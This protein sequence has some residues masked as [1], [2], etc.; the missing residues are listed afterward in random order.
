MPEGTMRMLS[1]PHSRLI[2]YRI[3]MV[4]A[5]TLFL[6]L[7]TAMAHADESPSARLA[8]LLEERQQWRLREFPEFAIS[9]GDYR[10]ADHLADMSLA[11]VER[12]NMQTQECLDR[13]H[14]IPKQGLSESD[15][16]SYEVF[17]LSLSNDVEGHGYRMFLAPI[18]PRSGPHQDIPQMHERVRF[19]SPDDYVNYIQRLR[20]VPKSV[21]DL[22]ET[23][24]A[25]VKEG[26]TPPRV[27]LEGLT[28]QFKA[29]TA[30]GGLDG[31]KQP[32][33]KFPASF[34]EDQ[35][36]EFA[37]RLT[38][39]A[40]PLVRAA[41]QKLGAYVEQE[42][43]PGCRETIAAADLPNG[44]AYY[45]FRVREETTTPEP[46]VQIHRIGMR[47]VSRIKREMMAVIRRSDFL[48][49]HPQT[50]QLGDE[51][52]FAAFV[53]YLRTDPRFYHTSEDE[54]LRGYRDI[55]KRIDAELPRLF[56]T[57]PRLPYGVRAIPKFMAPTQ[58]T[59]YYQ[60]GDI[61]NS[62]AGYFFANTYRLDQR[63]KYEMIPL[64]L[65]EAVPGHHLQ[66][67]IAQELEGLPEFRKD[68]G[69]TAFVEGWALYSERLGIEMG[70]F[71]D[72]YDDFGRLLYEMWRACRLV[73]DPGMHALGWTRQ[74]AIDFMKTN[75]A[76]S[77]LNI[78]TEVDRYISWP[79]QAT[80]YKMG[81]LK[82]RELRDRAEQ[83][84][85]DTFD[86][87]EFHDVILGQGALP[88]TVLDRRVKEWI[89]T[90]RPPLTP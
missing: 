44:K 15:L 69:F 49:T 17:E 66:V 80:G 3:R 26:R 2:R 13:L 68:A 53:T 70:L 57:L 79:G 41:L 51:E 32:L 28:D 48:Q 55:C 71:A 39:E 78:Q 87:R 27:T 5:L 36:K 31:L 62:E 34:S 30:E 21:D 82:I 18:G 24:K 84:L 58:T 29:V 85:G 45:E 65:H 88:L 33:L 11:A 67:A 54:L 59:A 60:H 10:Y 83:V 25:G 75:T 61:R 6:L 47:E 89:E 64:T 7:T 74:Q 1:F 37:D 73:V 63:P 76:L 52:L 14:A 42:Y 46:A 9:R 4:K 35:R 43:L 22:I 20:G 90:N 72:P 81:E 86:L 77:D 23:L 50:G 8:A 16:V 19:A 38:T 12:R 56:R 40:I